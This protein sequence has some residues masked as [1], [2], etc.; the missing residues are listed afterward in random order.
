VR[1]VGRGPVLVNGAMNNLMTAALRFVPRGLVS[2]ATA[3]LLKPK[4]A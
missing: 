1:A 2:R 3:A 4:E